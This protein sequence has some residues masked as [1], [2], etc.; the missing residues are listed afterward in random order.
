ME[1]CVDQGLIRSIGL[2]NFNSRQIQEIIDNSRIP[3]AVLQVAVLK[4][5]HT[6]A[7]KCDSRRISP[8]SRRFRRQSLFS[9]TVWTRLYLAVLEALASEPIS[10]SPLG[11]KS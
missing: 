9:A 6:V 2:S 4:P 8:L 5:V 1:A 3:P 10:V 7:E 11:N